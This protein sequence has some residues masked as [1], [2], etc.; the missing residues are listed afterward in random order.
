MTIRITLRR[1]IV[2]LA[3][4]VIAGL[5]F[6]WSGLFQVSASSGHWA[7][8]D[9]VLHW[10][11]RNSVRTHAAFQRSPALP[12]DTDL[13]SAA[14]H[15]RQACQICHGAPGVRPSPVM[16]RATPPAPDLANL[17]DKWSARQL[18]WII[19]HGV[20]MT[21]M[22]AWGTAGR[23][24]EIS[25]MT[26]FVRRLP[27]MTATQYQSLTEDPPTASPQGLRPGVL[28][29]CTGCHGTDGRGRG[30]SDI[31][32]LG[33]QKPAYLRAALADYASGQRHSAVMQAAVTTLTANEMTILSGYFATMPG[34]EDS[35]PARAHP[36]FSEGLPERQLPACSRCH[37]PGKSHPALAVQKPAYIAARLR[38]WRGDD[39]IV[40]ARK[41]SATMAMIARRIPEKDIDAVAQALSSATPPPAPQ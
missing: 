33:G 21:G 14:G 15:Y 37:A 24:D 2:A 32:I 35:L 12:P 39:T 27:G 30:Q 18:A 1:L 31:P 4:L 40:D 22:P 11:M 26:A 17:G 23:A 13:V 3:A 38:A 36:F 28:A 19:E 5:L 20:K 7:I 10:T 41:S 6:A 34:V 9:W 25:R 16:Q 8:T 29:A